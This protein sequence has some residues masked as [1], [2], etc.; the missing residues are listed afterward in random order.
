MALGKNS[1]DIWTGY[2]FLFI[3]SFFK[4]WNPF[5]FICSIQNVFIYYTKYLEFLFIKSLQ[6]LFIFYFPTVILVM[7]NTRRIMENDSAARR[8][9]QTIS[10]RTLTPNFFAFSFFEWSK[11]LE[12]QTCQNWVWCIWHVWK[13]WGNLV[14]CFL[15]KL[16]Y[17]KGVGRLTN[18][19]C[20]W[21]IR[22]Q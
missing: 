13:V 14:V 22:I 6:I 9:R 19:T 10:G 8:D 3:Y 16:T 12:D 21:T 1:S 17:L 15:E 7:D 2:L 4:I 11:T 5:L 18:V 20:L